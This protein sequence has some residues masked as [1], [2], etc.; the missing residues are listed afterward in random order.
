MGFADFMN[1]ADFMDC[2]AD[3]TD[4]GGGGGHIFHPYTLNILGLSKLI[5]TL[6]PHPLLQKNMINSPD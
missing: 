1:I 5:K 6:N 2:F 3:F 4:L